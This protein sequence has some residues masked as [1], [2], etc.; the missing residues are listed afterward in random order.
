VHIIVDFYFYFKDSILGVLHSRRESRSWIL[1][2]RHFIATHLLP[3]GEVDG[4]LYKFTRSSEIG[5]ATDDLTK[6]IHAF[7]HFMLIYTSGFLLLSDLQGLYDARCVM[8]L[9][10]P[11]GHTYVSTG[12]V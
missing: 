11:Q 9:F 10:D 4:P 1:P 7:A 2:Y 6:V 3:C 12:L 5:P 8:C